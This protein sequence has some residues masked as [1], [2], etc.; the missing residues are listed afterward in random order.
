MWYHLFPVIGKE[1][2]LPIYLVSI[3]INKYQYHVD[4]KDGYP[5]PQIL[6]SAHGEGILKTEGKV[7]QIPPNTA[8]FLPPNIPHEYYAISEIWDTRW[9]IADGY[10]LDN[11]LGC[12]NL[13]HTSVFKFQ[14]ISTLDAILDRMR[15]AIMADDIMGNY[16][17]SG[18]LYEFLTTFHRLTSDSFASTNKKTMYRLSP[19]V[20]YIKKN[21]NQQITM[22]KLCDT[23][24]VSPQHL[25]RLFKEQLNFRPMEYVCQ[26]RIQEAKNLLAN[27]SLPI[28]AIA[29]RCGFE[30]TNYFNKMFKKYEN[31]TPGMFRFSFRMISS[32]T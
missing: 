8:F 15:S 27:T 3:G 18:I 30:N 13:D 7:Y 1:K 10:A 21:Y 28:H 23:I 31:M 24:L 2:E 32:K 6:F 4:R 19:V 26:I 11:M 25:C 20:A 16:T 14:D 9:V 29:L 17:A 22:D 12:M 5:L